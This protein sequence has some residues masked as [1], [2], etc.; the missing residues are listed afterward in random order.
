MTELERKALLGDR[1]AQ[2]KCTE[3]GI[4][5]SCPFCGG[6]VEVYGQDDDDLYDFVCDC[7]AIFSVNIENFKKTLA[8]WNTRQAPPIG[9]CGECKR[10]HLRSGRYFCEING[11]MNM[12]DYCSY[13]E[14]RCEE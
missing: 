14:P 8:A 13:F 3:K 12:D 4:V 9:R 5:L 1:E 10:I 11:V 6:K 2:Q 7:G